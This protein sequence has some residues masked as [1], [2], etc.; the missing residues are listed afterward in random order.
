MAPRKVFSNRWEV[1]EHISEG[2]QSWVYEV[3]DL[4]SAWTD[5]AV[6]KRLK[7]HNRLSRFEREIKATKALDHPSI[8]KIVDYSLEDPAFYVTPLYEGATLR[9]IAPLDT[10]TAID[11]FIEICEAIAYAHAKGVT[12]RD[13]KPENIILKKNQRVVV[14]DFGL[15]YLEDEDRLTETM[16]QVGSRFY[17]A[18]E[19][20][21]GRAHAVTDLVDSYSLGKLLYFL[22]VGRDLHRESFSGENNLVYLFFAISN[23]VT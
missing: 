1:V 10:L 12:H 22:L 21:A 7:N 14:L 19:L 4:T 15:C 13:I 20:E 9:E 3:R 23:L 2:G 17:M 18:P 6:L 11:L 5:R 8:A 16:E